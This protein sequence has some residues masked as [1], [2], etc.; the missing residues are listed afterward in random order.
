MR[1]FSQAV[2][3]V[4]SEPVGSSGKVK[5]SLENGVPTRPCCRSWTASTTRTASRSTSTCTSGRSRSAFGN[6]DGDQAML[7]YV[8]G[9][10]GPSLGLIVHHD[11]AAREVAYD[12][13]SKIGKLNTARRGPGMGLDRG[14]H[15]GR[16]GEGISVRVV[17]R[18]AVLPSGG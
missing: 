9:G 11:D 2:Y 1:T 5:F 7:E 4:A 18:A 6:S 3:G 17:K 16:L 13:D 15:E 8:T 10:D 12:R 14:Q